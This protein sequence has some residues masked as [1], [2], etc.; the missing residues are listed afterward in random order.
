MSLHPP[1]LIVGARM[2]YLVWVPAD[3]A[4]AAGLVPAELTAAEGAPVFINQYLVDDAA[5][6][7]N[8][9]SPERSLPA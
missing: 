4:A 6:T 9:A 7:S 2:L 8:A 5:Q 3:P 1:Q